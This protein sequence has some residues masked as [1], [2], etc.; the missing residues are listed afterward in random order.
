MCC[1]TE[2][3]HQAIHWGTYHGCCCSGHAPRGSCL[4]PVQERADRL[5]RYL[6]GL[7]EEIK[8]VEAQLSELAEEE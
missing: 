1:G 5:K 7:R 2:R 3:H 4:P 6:E 8:A